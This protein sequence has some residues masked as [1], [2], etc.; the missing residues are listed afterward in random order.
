MKAMDTNPIRSRPPN[1]FIE[2]FKK[3]DRTSKGFITLEDIKE[4]TRTLNEDTDEEMM[5]LMI[6][7][8]SKNQDKKLTF[9]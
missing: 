5:Q 7:R 6:E 3:Y 9:S 2:S 8:A 1:R 4:M